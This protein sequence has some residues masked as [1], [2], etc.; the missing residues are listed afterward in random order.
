M[1]IFFLDA[2]GAKAVVVE[3]NKDEVNRACADFISNL[4]YKQR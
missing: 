4:D 3:S 2:C 1:N